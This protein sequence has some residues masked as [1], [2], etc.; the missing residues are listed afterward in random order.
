MHL[1][2]DFGK[3]VTFTAKNVYI[4]GEL[5]AQLACRFFDD[6]GYE[7]YTDIFTMEKNNGQKKRLK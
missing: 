7:Y 3:S 2:F 4:N 6:D 1:D 5:L